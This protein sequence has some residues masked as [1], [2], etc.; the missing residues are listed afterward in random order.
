MSAKTTGVVTNKPPHVNTKCYP[1]ALGFHIFTVD[2]EVDP[3]P[4]NMGTIITISESNGSVHQYGPNFTTGDMVEIIAYMDSDLPKRMPFGCVTWFVLDLLRVTGREIV[5]IN[6]E[7]VNECN[8]NFRIYTLI[9]DDMKARQLSKDIARSHSRG[10]SIYD[11]LNIDIES[12]HILAPYTIIKSYTLIL[13]VLRLRW[14]ENQDEYL[15]VRY[16][17][18]FKLIP[19]N[20]DEVNEITPDSESGVDD[21][22]LTNFK[23][24]LLDWETHMRLGTRLF[25]DLVDEPM[26]EA[27]IVDVDENVVT[28]SVEG[29]YTSEDVQALT[30]SRGD[31]SIIEIHTHIFVGNEILQNPGPITSHRYLSRIFN[32]EWTS[33]GTAKQ[34]DTKD[35]G[36][37]LVSKHQRH[38]WTRARQKL[39]LRR[40]SR[41]CQ[42]AK[43]G[44][45][46]DLMSM[47][48]Q[49]LD[50]EQRQAVQSDAWLTIVEGYPG[51]GKTKTAGAYIL[52]RFQSL[53]ELGSGWLVV[54]TNTN[55]SAISVLKQVV[56]YPSLQ[57]YILHVYSK[58]RAAY[59]RSMFSVSYE[60][61]LTPR[62]V[63]G[64]HGI[65]ICT[66][67]SLARVIKKYIGFGRLVRDL[68]TDESGQMWSLFSVLFLRHFPHL[69]RWLQLGDR[70]QLP[71]YVSKLL[72]LGIYFPSVMSAFIGRVTVT[73]STP[74]VEQD[75][76]PS[77]MYNISMEDIPIFRLLVQ[78]RM[79]K[80]I[81]DIH[82]PLFYDYEIQTAR[83]GVLNPE[84]DGAYISYMAAASGM[85]DED[86]LAFACNHAFTLVQEIKD[87]KLV[88]NDGN[89]YSIAVLTAHKASKVKYRAEAERLQISQY[90][91]IFTVDSIQ[92]CE[93]N[94]VIL[95]PGVR[96][97]TA[98]YRCLARANV[99]LSRARDVLIA[100]LPAKFVLSVDVEN[101]GLRCWGK[102]FLNPKLKI[103][104]GITP[105]V[106]LLR[107]QVRSLSQKLT[108]TT[109]AVD[110]RISI[111]QQRSTWIRN[112]V[113]A[114]GPLLESV[115]KLV[116]FRLFLKPHYR[117]N[118]EW[119][120]VCYH[121][122][123]QLDDEGFR[124]V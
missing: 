78:Y 61:R 64:P 26:S 8:N 43:K 48:F 90:V 71:P 52:Q 30:I 25:V 2:T 103:W 49:Q 121:A 55:A 72:G 3:N 85:T 106:E 60:Y 105:R 6:L 79:N 66:I 23:V 89:A 99:M 68:V 4:L 33:L 5:P 84:I 67:G 34:I 54:L 110:G 41:L 36:A 40:E 97:P 32:V 21:E 124:Q 77:T 38:K 29:T 86:Y 91:E 104:G 7:E 107:G 95:A 28:F 93:W 58:D 57:R 119:Q 1:P 42:D 76:S 11:D 115:R 117:R 112:T 109:M 63:L 92:G 75:D 39:L 37:V 15:T 88:D 83:E 81:C 118:H 22:I 20:S 14:L 17:D 123:L 50:A 45:V 35:D 120:M 101:R 116:A 62:R 94:V 44:I 98:L 87:H 53:L 102:M 9:R 111:R 65:L 12:I 18:L 51:T 73:G 70:R 82:R 47:N 114:E 13:G 24:T 108:Q 19:G 113:P 31:E 27:N 96:S 122:T 56:Q 46:T 100:C 10:Q 80:S 59:D 16:S 69:E 74:E